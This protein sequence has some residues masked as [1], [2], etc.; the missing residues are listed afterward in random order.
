MVAA[1]EVEQDHLDHMLAGRAAEDLVQE[2]LSL[3]QEQEQMVL[4]AVEAV[5][6]MIQEIQMVTI[7]VEM[8]L[9]F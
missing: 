6:Q 7:Q 9:L 2:F 5:Q 3:N 1:A 4:A 8:E